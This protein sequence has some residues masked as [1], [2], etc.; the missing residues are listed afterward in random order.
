MNTK[1]FCNIQ[2][3]VLNNPNTNADIGELTTYAETYS[4]D[5]GV[6]MDPSYPEYTINN[7]HSKN[8][9]GAR[10]TL[11]ATLTTVMVKLVDLVVQNAAD[12]PGENF[13]HTVN[14]LMVDKAAAYGIFNIAVGPMVM[15]DNH[16]VCSWFSFSSTEIGDDNV[17]KIWLDIDAF[18]RQYPEYELVVVPPVPALDMFFQSP[19]LVR[20]MISNITIAGVMSKAQTARGTS[21]DTTTHADTYDYVDPSNPANRTPVP[22]VML[23]YGAA[24]SNLDLIRAELV[25]YILT[26]STHSKADWTLIFPDIFK[27]TEFI[28]APF[29]QK[30]A[31]PARALTHGVN[32]PIVAPSEV[33]PQLA[34][35]CPGYSDAHI[36]RNMLIVSHVFRSLQLAVC[37]GMDNR[38]AHFKISDLF[39]DYIAVPTTSTDFNRMGLKTQNFALLLTDLLNIADLYDDNYDIPMGTTKTT[40]SGLTY[41]VRSIDNVQYL[42]LAK[43]SAPPA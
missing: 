1:S 29:W 25:D 38:N 43:S 39:P 17:H 31:L 36:E 5:I 33:K 15:W 7:F 9:A 32:S 34:Y 20:Q 13:T 12:N 41:V 40:R 24:G 27:A 16:S 4:K 6:Y 19:A 42:V 3:F 8:I 14:A 35:A 22:W 26:N 28:I 23:I 37:G 2:R 11:S 10:V 30:M 18:L 21:P